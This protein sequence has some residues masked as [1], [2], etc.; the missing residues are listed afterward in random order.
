MHSVYTASQSWTLGR[1][2]SL[3][4]GFYIPEDD[5]YWC[6]YTSLLQIINY[7]VAPEI[8]EDEVA[9]PKVSIGNFLSEFIDLYPGASVIPKMHYMVHIPRLTMK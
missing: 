9:W 5:S 4:V 7:A 2:I 1:L 3:M 6:H 8:S